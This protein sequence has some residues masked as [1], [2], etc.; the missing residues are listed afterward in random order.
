MYAWEFDKNGRELRVRVEGQL[1]FN[2]TSQQV[3]ASLAGL[4]L[5][6]APEGMVQPYVARGKLRRVLE[7]GASRILA[8]T[9]SIQAAANPPR[10]SRWSSTRCVIGSEDRHVPAHARYPIW[11][12]A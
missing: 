11:L 5:V 10:R 3:N 4:G 12:R 6:Y 7:V 9:Y 1:T 8:I 2:A